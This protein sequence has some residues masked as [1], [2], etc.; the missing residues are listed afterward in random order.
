M[1]SRNAEIEHLK[2]GIS[3]AALL[4]RLPPPWRL[5]RRE[6][7]RHNLKYRRGA[8]EILIVNHA[9]R[10]WWDPLS[11][12]KGDVLS[13]VRHLDPDLSFGDA[14]R[15]LRGFAGCAYPAPALLFP[16]RP[17]LVP[18]A[19]RWNRRLPLSRGSPAW[20]YLTRQRGLPER[21]LIAAGQTDALREGPWGSAWFAHRNGTGAVTGIEMR[22]PD[23]RGFSA[24]GG[25]ALFVLRGGS[26]RLPRIAI[27]E[28]AIDALSLAAIED[29]RPD[30]L[31]AATAGGMGPG[32]VTAL[33]LLLQE[34]AADPAA[35]L[36]AATDAD[37]AGR[38]Y[39]A[40]LAAM[41][42]GWC[43][44]FERL[45]PPD[46]LKDWNDVL[47]ALARGSPPG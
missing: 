12:A 23:W 42:A 4:E 6:S 1:D 11:S 47:R 15:L 21:I 37:D 19:E 14:C 38:N 7:S 17:V 2:A 46:G 29:L 22:G 28:S 31:Y 44:G 5:D 18:V 25:K 39:A 8:D 20:V 9:G 41:A 13:L 24:G 3:C 30:T 35:R 10:G 16:D 43:V 40:R 34:R 26:A 27:L 36:I 33:A 32:T 45:L